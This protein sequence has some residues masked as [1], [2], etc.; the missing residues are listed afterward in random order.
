MK[1]NLWGRF[2]RLLR[3]TRHVW[4]ETKRETLGRFTDWG[5][6]PLDITTM[7]RIA[8]HEECLL[9]GETRVWEFHSLHP[10]DELRRRGEALT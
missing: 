6:S 7:Y 2:C 4:K 1:T 3:P 5:S 8:V 9:T 10:E